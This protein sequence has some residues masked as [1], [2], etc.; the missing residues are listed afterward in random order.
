MLIW[1]CCFMW[2]MLSF[3]IAHLLY[4]SGFGMKPLNPIA[5]SVCAT[6]AALGI[7]VLIDGC[8]GPYVVL[9]PIYTFLL[10]FMVWRAVARVQLFED[11]WTWTKLCSC[12]GGILFVV[13]DVIIGINMFV[14]PIPYANMLIMVTYYA[15]QLGIALS[16]VD[17][18][19]IAVISAAHSNDNNQCCQPMEA[20]PVQNKLA[21]LKGG[22][23]HA[24][25]YKRH[26]EVS[27]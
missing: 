4:I 12:G 22:S 25:A 9:V 26:T 3:G 6:A 13:S 23:E 17:S 16:V 10:M 18:T 21:V 27:E 15:A 24:T 14:S 2:G 19:S 11:L 5:G 8:D 20:N 1:P 7:F